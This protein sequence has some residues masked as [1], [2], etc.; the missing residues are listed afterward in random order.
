MPNIIQI[1]DFKNY[2]KTKTNKRAIVLHGTYSGNAKGTINWLKTGSQ[3]GVAVHYVIGEGG[4]IYKLFP[5]SYFAY[6]CGANFRTLSRQSFGIEITNWLS[7]Q[8][9]Q[10][11]KYYTWTNKIISSDEVLQT[12][13]WRG[14]R[15]WQK[16][17][18]KQLQS[19][20]LLVRYLCNQYNI[21]KKVAIYKQ[22]MNNIDTF[23]GICFHS[24]F[25]PTRQD[26]VPQ[27]CKIIKEEI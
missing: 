17:N 15:Y 13:E 19:I 6:H 7:L 4:D 16:I 1:P 3:K 24:T 5:E 8:K 27:I 10:N 9:R 21:Q 14:Y 23:N 18:E 12:P 25:H 2:I 11:K 22:E 26:F 20:Y